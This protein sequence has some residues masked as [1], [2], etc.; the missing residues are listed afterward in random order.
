MEQVEADIV[1]IGSGAG[2]GTVAS[3]L[4]EL[5]REGHRVIVLEQGPRFSHHHFT[6]R[7][8]DMGDHLYR[9]GGAFMTADSTVS[10]AFAEG[11]GGSTMVYTG[12]SLEPA[13][14]VIEQWKVPGLEHSDLIERID[15]HAR[16]NNVAPVPE[17]RLNDNNRLF[18]AGCQKLGWE[19]RR[20][21]IN[22]R[23]CKG[24]SLC[25]LGCPNDA[26]Q[27]THA[28]QLPHAESE[29]V[30]V[31]TRACVDHIGEGR[32]EFSVDGSPHPLGYRSEWSPGRY[33][34]RAG[35][36]VLAAGAVGT[37]ALMLRSGYGSSLPVLGQY[38]TCQPAHILVARHEH[39]L[40]NA[41][42]HPKSYLWDER[43]ESERHFL[44]VCMY[45]P[46]IAAKNMS[47]FG[48]D[49][50]YFLHQFDHLQMI[51]VLA[52][53][54]ARPEH[55]VRLDRQGNP[56][57]DYALTGPTIDAL[58]HGTRAAARIFFAAGATDVH[59]PSAR[60][61]RL[62]AEHADDVD[63]HIRPEHFRTGTVSVSAAHLMGGCRMGTDRNSSVTDS[64]GRVYGH[65]GL[66]VADASLFPSAIETNPYQT[67]MALA[68]RVAESI[69]ERYTC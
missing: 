45:P 8:A 12:S 39:P 18:V 65:P 26:K 53:D 21:P 34:I 13:E 25:N 32:V 59:A 54:E 40:T 52:C 31:V 20:F 69:I 51:L 11:Y 6:G 14:R 64:H 55:R 63:G 61:M 36:I 50:E 38:F 68:D 28:V 60:P 30:E 37:P 49:H 15:R 19:A 56:V 23:G 43:I 41:V 46:F 10:L 47:G 3:R 1:I 2:G 9:D 48:E 33:E 44:E 27:G 5:A 4:S 22:L 17:E 66:Y 29:G 42:G 16:D 67:I 7:E 58:V 24:S 35:T 57:V 62:G